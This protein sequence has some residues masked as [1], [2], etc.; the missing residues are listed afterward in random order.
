[1]HSRTQSQASVRVPMHR[2]V[3]SRMFIVVLA[4]ACFLMSPPTMV[5]QSA[6]AQL[7]EAM[8]DPSPAFVNFFAVRYPNSDT[9]IISGQIVG[10]AN[11]SN[12]EVSIRGAVSTSA[13]TDAYGNFGVTVDY[14]GLPNAVTADADYEGIPIP[15]A[16]CL[17]GL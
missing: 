3:V 9:W 8:D 12:I 15:Q 6:W 7:P 2:I 10:C 4:V 13:H 17:I 5:Q 16:V 14:D 1:M 11:P